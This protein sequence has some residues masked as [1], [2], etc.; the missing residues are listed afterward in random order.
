AAAPAGRRGPPREP[1]RELGVLGLQPALDLLETPPFVLVEHRIVSPAG[2][3]AHVSGRGGLRVPARSAI[4]R[5]ADRSPRR[6]STRRA[7]GRRRGR[8]G[9]TSPGAPGVLRS[10]RRRT[11]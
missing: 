2:P 6:P 7:R 4:K 8:G 1:L 3:R 9:R 11:W 10:P 5:R